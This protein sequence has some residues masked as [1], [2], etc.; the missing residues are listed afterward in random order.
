MNVCNMT[1]YLNRQN[2][3]P[4]RTGEREQDRDNKATLSWATYMH[5]RMLMLSVDRAS[6][7]SGCSSDIGH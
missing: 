2:V 4:Q 5:A 3:L 7:T 6:Y 1:H